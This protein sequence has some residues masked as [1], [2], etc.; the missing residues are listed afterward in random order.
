[1][2]APLRIDS[3]VHL[4]G[5]D[6]G[7]S[8]CWISPRFQKRYTFRLLR[9]WHG[10]TP[11]QLRDSIDQDWVDRIASHVRQSELD[12]AVVLGFDGSYSGDATAIVAVEL[13]DVP[14]I[15]VVRVWEPAEGTPGSP[16]RTPRASRLTAP[17]A[18]S[19]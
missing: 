3:H 1:M 18:R 6:T 11:E 7:D 8:G 17:V 12:R 19:S 2:T 5:V 15:D 10:I 9:W 13:G 4:A 14:H 16:C